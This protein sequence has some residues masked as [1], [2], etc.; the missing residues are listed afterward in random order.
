[1]TMLKALANWLNSRTEKRPSL[2]S[3]INGTQ[4]VITKDYTGELEPIEKS[5]SQLVLYDENLLE[6][7]RTEWECG[8]W[9]SLAKIERGALQHHPDRAKLALLAAA[10][11]QQI[12]D[13]SATRQFTRL[14]Q[15]WGCN[16]KLV[17]QILIAGV[18]NTLGSVAALGK[19]ERHAL[20]HFETSITIGAP[21]SDW[22]HLVPARMQSQLKN[23]KSATCSSEK[24]INSTP[25][26]DKKTTPVDCLLTSPF[27]IQ[28]CNKLPLPSHDK[29]T[30]INGRTIT[31]K[32]IEYSGRTFNFF[33]RPKSKGDTGVI[34]QLFEEKQYEF[35]WL[36]QG[37]LIYELFKEMIRDGQNPL[38]IDAGANIGASCIWFVLKFEKSTIL[39]IEPDTDNCE[40]LKI[41]N[42]NLP[43]LLFQG[44]LA[45]TARTLK[46]Q[47]PGLSDWGF[48]VG[49]TGG[50]SIDCIG[51]DEII[52]FCTL[53]NYKP[54]ILKIDI[55]GGESLVFDGAC[56]W[57][58]QI[59]MI[60]IEL[61]DWMFPGENSSHNFLKAITGH[62]FE[63]ITR[64]EN[65]MCFNQLLLKDLNNNQSSKI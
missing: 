25:R 53:N 16:K 50:R 46:L 10:G 37:K 1:M 27:E 54:F 32:I 26:A 23:L 33:Y 36:P 29:L 65:I 60:I 41:N 49:P 18:H 14:A 40:L 42:S 20:K 35:G 17:S 39:A 48:R 8:D 6:R 31:S 57:L 63:I 4:P 30:R 64:G 5:T 43:V 21:G 58:K 44:A 59:P 51:P 55:E 34:K 22:K 2:R 3:D 24:L 45:D 9:D 38:I 52:K 11:H 12:G 62:K 19:E 13:M 47:D 15:D 56:E 7:S 28:N 61:H